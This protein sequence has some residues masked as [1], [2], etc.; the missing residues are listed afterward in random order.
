MPTIG[1]GSPG[2]IKSG[3]GRR[4]SAMMAFG[5]GSAGS[6]STVDIIPTRNG[7]VPAFGGGCAA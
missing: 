4:G 7:S 5:A 3:M 6:Q 2:G 1:S